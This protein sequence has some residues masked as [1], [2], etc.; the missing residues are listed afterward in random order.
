M[1]YIIISFFR[2]EAGAVYRI[3]IDGAWP[4]AGLSEEGEYIEDVYNGEVVS[5]LTFLIYLN[6]DFE[7]GH[8][9]FFINNKDKVK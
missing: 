5:K 8:T 9:T 1:L 2:Y 6:D 3:H 4:G 7:G